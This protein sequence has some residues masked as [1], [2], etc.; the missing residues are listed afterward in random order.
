VER[1]F[2][3]IRTHLFAGTGSHYPGKTFIRNSGIK[4]AFTDNQH[5]LTAIEL[6]STAEASAVLGFWE[7]DVAALIA[8]NLLIETAARS[9]VDFHS[10][11]NAIEQGIKRCARRGRMG[12]GSTLP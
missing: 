9:M 10:S 8:A 11:G 6:L 2:F 3:T 12:A 5:V 4:L 1:G 7:H